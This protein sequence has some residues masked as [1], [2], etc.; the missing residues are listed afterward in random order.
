MKQTVGDFLLRTLLVLNPGRA[1]PEGLWRRR[2]PPV[3]GCKRR[4]TIRLMIPQWIRP[5]RAAQLSAARNS[6]S[7]ARALGGSGSPPPTGWLD[8]GG[9]AAGVPSLLPDRS[10]SIRGQRQGG[11]AHVAGLPAEPGGAGAVCHSLDSL[12]AGAAGDAGQCLSQRSTG[13]EGDYRTQALPGAGIHGPISQPLSGLSVQTR[14]PRMHRPG[15]WS[16]SSGGFASQTLPRTL[17]IQIRF[18]IARCGTCRPTW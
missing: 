2:F 3:H 4:S 5:M 17:L 7:L 1:L 8:R 14:L 11:V 12:R 15:C 9:I 6:T 16:G 18:R 10:Q 13:L